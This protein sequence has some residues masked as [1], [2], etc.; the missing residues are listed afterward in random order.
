VISFRGGPRIEGTSKHG[1]GLGFGFLHG[2][3]PVPGKKYLL[4]SLVYPVESL[5][6]CFAFKG[7]L[8]GELLDIVLGL[9]S[10][11]SLISI[12]V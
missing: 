10:Y 8:K 6:L 2:L 4:W 12:V 1:W 9:W 11:I 7:H 3:S 5:L